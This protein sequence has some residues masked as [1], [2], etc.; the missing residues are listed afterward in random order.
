[1]SKKQTLPKKTEVSNVFDIKEFTC[2]RDLL[3]VVALRTAGKDGL[4]DPKQ[5]ED[6]PEFGKI[7]K[8]GEGVQDERLKV[9]TVIRFGKYSTEAIRTGGKDYFLIHEED[10]SAFKPN[11]TS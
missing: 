10:V 11:E 2:L 5:Y 8:L 3:L 9:G 6:K 4:I 1:M 7:I